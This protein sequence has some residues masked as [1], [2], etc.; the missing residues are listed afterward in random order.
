MGTALALG[1]AG[2]CVK[3]SGL[4]QEGRHRVSSARFDYWQAAVQT[5]VKT[6]FRQ[7]PGNFSAPYAKV[8]KPESEMARLTHNDYL[9]Q[10]SDSG[11]SGHG[12]LYRLDVG[13]L[14]VA[15]R[16]GDRDLGAAGG[17]AGIAGLGFARAWS[18]LGC[19]SRRWLG[20]HLRSWAGCWGSSNPSTAARRRLKSNLAEMKIL[21]LN[22]PNLNLL[23]Q[24]EPE[25]YGRPTLAD[26]EAKVRERAAN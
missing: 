25:V 12:V 1:L 24:R 26:I 13:S 23:G 15:V 10:S 11:V 21:F 20:Q 14:A 4:F 22:G 8:K 2:S 16:K 3:Y 17:L 18:N 19:T 7:R 6:R 5:A 9:E